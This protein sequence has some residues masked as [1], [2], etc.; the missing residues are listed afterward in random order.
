MPL[1]PSGRANTKEG[2]FGDTTP[3]LG[4][5]ATA[6]EQC[7]V[8]EPIQPPGLSIPADA[9][10]IAINAAADVAKEARNSAE[11]IR[12]S[13]INE[14]AVTAAEQVAVAAE[15]AAFRWAF[16]APNTNSGDATAAVKVVAVAARNAATTAQTAAT[17]APTEVTS[18]ISGAADKVAAAA[19]IIREFYHLAA[20]DDFDD[21]TGKLPPSHACDCSPTECQRWSGEYSFEMTVP[22]NPEPTSQLNWKELFLFF[23]QE[24]HVLREW[25]TIMRRL[26]LNA[27]ILEEISSS[28]NPLREKIYDA[29]DRWRV[30]NVA[31]DVTVAR[32]EKALREEGLVSVAGMSNIVLDIYC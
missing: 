15:A 19:E 14:A 31:E 23:C 28:N 2:H 20:R 5:T 22:Q 16:P 30:S 26:D 18:A 1:Q 8:P 10:A 6:T 13:A 17:D 24:E 21:G 4:P 11:A 3:E 27:A 9:V 32:I 25:K 29:F 7:E 12:T